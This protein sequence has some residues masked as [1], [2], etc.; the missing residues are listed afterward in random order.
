[1][2]SRLPSPLFNS[3]M[4]RSL[5]LLVYLIDARI[6]LLSCFFWLLYFSIFISLELRVHYSP[7]VNTAS[8]LALTFP[9]H[10]DY[11]ILDNDLLVAEYNKHI[12]PDQTAPEEQSDQGLFVCAEFMSAKFVLELV[13]LIT[14]PFPP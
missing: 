6:C 5:G 14:F 11:S 9:F 10:W 4:L 7:G 1:M 8:S 2:P 3:L 12:V 13:E